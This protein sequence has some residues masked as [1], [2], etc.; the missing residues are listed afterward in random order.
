MRSDQMISDDIR[1]HRM[2]LDDIGWHRMRSVEIGWD[3]IGSDQMTSDKIGSDY[4]RWDRIRSQEIKWDQMT[5]EISWDRI[6]LD[7]IGA[8]EI[9]RDHMR[10]Y[11]IMIRNLNKTDLKDYHSYMILNIS[12]KFQFSSLIRSLS[13]TPLSS[14]VTWRTLRVPDWR[15][16]GRGSLLT[17]YF[18]VHLIPD[19]C[20]ISAWEDSLTDSLT[21][22]LASMA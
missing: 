7:Q 2:R 8:D 20:Q 4:I 11:E 22:T 1:G 13:R 15:H 9:R 21:D 6:R 16:E 18:S 5:D 14:S 19:A 3:R 17:T 10:S 12:A